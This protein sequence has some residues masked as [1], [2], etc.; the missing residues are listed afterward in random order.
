M[1][2]ARKKKQFSK[3]SVVVSLF[4]TLNTNH[5]FKFTFKEYQ[6]VDSFILAE[7]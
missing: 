5:D 1:C 6:H 3:K 7:N 2:K 4:T